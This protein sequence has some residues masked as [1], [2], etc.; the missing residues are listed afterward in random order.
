MQFASP[1]LPPGRYI[2]VEVEDDGAPLEAAAL[3]RLF[4]PFFT[5]KTDGRGLGLPLV[6]GTARAHGGAVEVE[7]SAGRKCFRLL[8]P[9]VLAPSQDPATPAPSST[10]QRDGARSLSPLSLRSPA[11]ILVVDDEPAVREYLEEALPLLGHTVATC[12]DATS[13]LQRMLDRPGTF[14]V[15]IL[16]MVLPD[17]RGTEVLHQARARGFDAPVILSS[18]FLPE[19]ISG[20]ADERID[21]FLQKPYDLGQLQDA[22][23]T[24]WSSDATRGR[25]AKEPGESIATG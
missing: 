8:L 13:G 11:H 17:G 12:D 25:P 18:G 7:A 2:A 4:E 22:L 14:D 23:E 15:V 9:T 21:A 6:L 5:T 1:L 24:V 10:A 20:Q 3:S 19:Q 16:D